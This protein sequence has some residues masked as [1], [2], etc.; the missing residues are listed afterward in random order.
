M[1]AGEES[2]TVAAKLR[3][4]V[5]DQRA[6]GDKKAEPVAPDPVEAD[7]PEPAAPEAEVPEPAAPE[8]EVPKPAPPKVDIDLGSEWDPAKRPPPGIERPAERGAAAGAAI[9]ARTA[10]FGRWSRGPTGRLVLPGTLLFALI[11][12]TTVAGAVVL[13]ANAPP[14]AH[15]SPA[16]TPAS[17]PSATAGT[18]LP[19]GVS[20]TEPVFPIP[21][22]TATTDAAA[23]PPPVAGGAQPADV[24]TTWAQ[25]VAGKTGISATAVR[26]Y[27]YAELVAGQ[28][29]PAC[30]ISWTTL[31]AIGKVESA[32]GTANGSTLASNGQTFPHIIGLPLDG[33]GDRM[34]ITDTDDGQLDGDP[35][36]D[37]AVGPMQFIPSTWA[38]SGADADNDGIK[39]PHDIDDAAL[40]A[41]NYLCG[42][43]RD[44]SNAQ[45][46]WGAILSYNDVRRYAQDV[47]NAANDYGAKSRT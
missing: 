13:P 35:T 45:D 33:Q 28:N 32:H 30:H 26:A 46:W 44:L 3:A 22:A 7:P 4:S 8:A 14:A 16:G 40:A 29:N 36:Y 6:P 9:K 23:T 10:A 38:S 31:A 20:P 21:T 17:D 11:G 24:L 43:G 39:D 47:F 19:T 2:P 42:N 37:R 25:Q 12:V 15:P 41:A 1:G 27:G 5:P 18:G 34:R